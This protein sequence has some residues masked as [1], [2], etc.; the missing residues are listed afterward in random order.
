M[1]TNAMIKTVILDTD[2]EDLA[3]GIRR[4]PDSTPFAVTDFPTGAQVRVHVME[5][6]D[7]EFDPIMRIVIS[8]GVNDVRIVMSP[9]TARTLGTML[10]AATLEDV[11]EEMWDRRTVDPPMARLTKRQ[12]H[13]MQ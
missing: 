4:T 7:E 5:D 1:D 11:K 6:P 8:D 13:Y 2:D 3:V 12:A 10:C 9:D